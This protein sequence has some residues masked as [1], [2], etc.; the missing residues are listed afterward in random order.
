MIDITSVEL[1]TIAYY[2]SFTVG[3]IIGI[4]L[5]WATLFFAVMLLDIV[6]KH[7]KKKRKKK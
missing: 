3:I 5:T 7:K 1:V 4:A 2:F 6:K